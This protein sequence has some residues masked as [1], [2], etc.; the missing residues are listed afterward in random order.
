MLGRKDCKMT[1]KESVSHVIIAEEN[2]IFQCNKKREHALG[3]MREE[4]TN[5]VFCFYCLASDFVISCFHCTIWERM[6]RGQWQTGPPSPPLF[7]PPR[8]PH[9]HLVVPTRR[10]S[11]PRAPGPSLGDGALGNSLTDAKGTALLLLTDW[12]VVLRDI[13]NLLSGRHCIVADP[14]A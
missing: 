4:S 7:P 11:A 5:P 13:V 8:L 10:C 12:P 9:C 3:R 2:C 14:T 6:E 1:N